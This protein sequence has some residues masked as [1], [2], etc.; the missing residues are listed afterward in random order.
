[1]VVTGQFKE[2]GSRTSVRRGSTDGS[3]CTSRWV[4]QF[5]TI[6]RG[7]PHSS[8]KIWT[9]KLKK[10]K[11]IRFFWPH[12][13]SA[14]VEWKKFVDDPCR[15]HQARS[16]G[17]KLG[18]YLKQRARNPLDLMAA[19]WDIWISHG[20]ISKLNYSKTR[21]PMAIIKRFLETGEWDE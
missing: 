10:S 16:Y 14:M 13:T 19:Y 5:E 8:Q 18:W 9:K 20:R 6:K 1:M 21:S 17:E 11:K 7:V 15:G 12:T 4:R 3:Y 2:S